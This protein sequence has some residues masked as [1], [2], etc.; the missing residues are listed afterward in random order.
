MGSRQGFID[1]R[2]TK[3]HKLAHSPTQLPPHHSHPHK[4]THAYPTHK[5]DPLIAL[6]ARKGDQGEFVK[7]GRTEMQENKVRGMIEWWRG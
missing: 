1:D 2:Y 6:Y 4:H 3:T 7:L 5:A